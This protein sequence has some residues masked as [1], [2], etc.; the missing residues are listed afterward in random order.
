MASPGGARVPFGLAVEASAAQGRNPLAE[1]NSPLTIG[2]TGDRYAGVDRADV[3]REV[4][5]DD[6]ADTAKVALVLDT[7]NA[8]APAS[9]DRAL[10]PAA[11]KRLWD[12]P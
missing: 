4:L 7:L 2:A 5:G 8:H 1:V 11:A 3:V 9:L 10:E 6:V 12:K